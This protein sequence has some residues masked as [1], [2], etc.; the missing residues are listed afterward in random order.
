MNSRMTSLALLAATTLVV[1]ACSNNNDSYDPPPPA[2]PAANQAP[3]ISAILDVA[4]DQDTVVGP[5][6]FGVTDTQTDAAQ[7]MVTA[8][9]DGTGLFPADG[10]ALGGSGVG[11]TLTL[12]PL[13]AATGTATITLTVMD[14]QG[15]ASTRSFTVTVN[16]RPASL[17]DVTL[18]SFAKG[19]AEEATPVN[20][21]TFAQDANDPAIF[22]PLLG[23]P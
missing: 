1:A 3:L 8:T 11:R 22:D 12:T 9:T 21:F 4:V 18:A 14:P 6:A 2:P 10:V 23:A 16:A 19:R 5:I 7:L 13:E 15:L 20:G 17:R